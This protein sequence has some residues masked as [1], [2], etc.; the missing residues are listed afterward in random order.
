MRT[1]II[2]S[3]VTIAFNETIAGW[4]HDQRVFISELDKGID[5]REFGPDEICEMA[6]QKA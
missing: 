3:A 2:G 1:L 4:L 6:T 5:L